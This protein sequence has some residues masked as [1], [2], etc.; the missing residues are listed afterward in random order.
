MINT[1]LTHTRTIEKLLQQKQLFCA[2]RHLDDLEALLGVSEYELQ[3]Q[4]LNPKYHLFTVPK[5]DGSKRW[6]EDPDHELQQIQD[7]L[8]DFLQS[9]YYFQRSDA[10]YG[11]MLCPKGDEQPRHI[12]SNAARHLGAPWL[13]NAD[14]EDF[15]HQV[16]FERV[17]QVFK[18]EPFTFEDDLAA[19]LTRL[20][21]HQERLPMGAPTSPVLSNFA[22]VK[23]DHD[24]QQLAN[25]AGWTYTRYADDMVFSSQ[26]E[27]TTE[28]IQ[29]IRQ[30]IED[31][32]Y[33]LKEPKLRLYRPDEIKQIT[34][35]ALSDTEVVVPNGFADMLQR[36]LVKLQ[37]VIEVHHRAGRHSAKWIEKYK[38]QV[39]G[40][41]NFLCY[42][43]GDDDLL[44][45]QITNQYKQA[46]KPPEDYDAVSWLDFPYF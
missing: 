44:S 46:I 8:N 26:N 40:R 10:A 18:G 22:T 2:I 28:N 30:I 23:L 15:F 17:F 41:V 32:G 24:L 12:V 25:W 38:Q 3:L 35:L 21:T 19:L 27:I 29:Q 11:F 13:F 45:Q 33:T 6:I 1:F 31:E 42:V 16:K 20:T 14:I 43:M 34:G 7:K 36:E 9:V 39:A 4:S 5:R 37:H